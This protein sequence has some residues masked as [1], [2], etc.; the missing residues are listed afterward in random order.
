[1]PQTAAATCSYC[2]FASVC[3]RGNPE[4]EMCVIGRNQFS[5]VG[6]ASGALLAKAMGLLPPGNLSVP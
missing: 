6:V 4:K 5:I 2:V 1:M 3:P